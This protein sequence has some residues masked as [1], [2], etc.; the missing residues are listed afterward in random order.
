MGSIGC[1]LRKNHSGMETIWTAPKVSISETLRKNHSGMETSKASYRNR[2]S[3]SCC[4]RT[5]VVWK[6]INIWIRRILFNVLRK[7]HSGME[8]GTEKAKHP[9]KY[10]LRKN[11]SGMETR[12]LFRSC[13]AFSC[14][15]A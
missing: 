13:S 2:C 15:V 14:C 10:L 5:I 3:Y 9:V 8:T 4:V 1:T 11:H 12:L 6:L 7:N